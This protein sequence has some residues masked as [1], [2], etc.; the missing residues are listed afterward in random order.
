MIES[1]IREFAKDN[2]IPIVRPKTSELLIEKVKEVDPN[3]ILEIGTAIGYSG[4]LML[5]NSTAKLVTLEKDEK[6]QKLALENFEKENLRDR[7][8]LIFG[9]AKDF[10]EKT[11][12]MFDL[13]FLDGPKGQ[14]LNYLPFLLKMLN[15]NGLLFCDNVL[16]GGQRTRKVG[17]DSRMRLQGVPGYYHLR[18]L[19]RLRKMRF[20]VSARRS[21]NCRRQSFHPCCQ[22]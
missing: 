13:I 14:Y 2:F 10:I 19:R 7:V 20:R 9:D 15:K 8:E 5:Q 3:N 17:T 21:G 18:E 1:E 12:Q 4:I 6:M 22:R 11:P 16:F